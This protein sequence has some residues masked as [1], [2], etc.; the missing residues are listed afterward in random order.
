MRAKIVNREKIQG[1]IYDHELTMRTTGE[2][3]KNPGTVYI[4][5]KV[6]VATDEACLNVVTVDFTYVTETTSK[7][8]KNTNFDVL[9]NIIENGKTILAD[10]KDAATMVSI[11]TSLGLNDFYTNRNGKDELVSAKK[12]DGGFINIVN[13]LD[14][15]ENAR[16][17][18]EVDMLING[19]RLVEA[20]PER[21]IAED[22]LI[23]KGAVFNSFRKT[24]LPVEL[25]CKNAGGMRYFQS[26]DA[27]TNNMVF[28][29]VW[30]NVESQTI[31]TK[32]E[33]ESAFGEPIVKEFERKSKD[34]LITGC[35]PEPYEI[36]DAENG[37]TLEEIKTMLADRE[38]Y[39]ADVKKRSDEYQASKNAAPVAS[40]SAP[41]AMGGFN[42]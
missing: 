23:V 4:R 33:E 29:K 11:D 39:L 26:L 18:F 3:S 36:G 13:R 14:A 41:A 25:T 38:T 35:K 30:G 24:I 7:G 34:W 17:K 37:I 1:R 42:F 21:N 12:N 8:A 32:V 16:N 27:S 10:G 31:V 5:G 2:S 19:T 6:D 22:Y 40:A 20:D 28:T 15:D 9:K